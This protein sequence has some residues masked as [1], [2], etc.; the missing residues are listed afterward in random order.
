MK[1][2]RN[3]SIEGA[4][5][6]EEQLNKHLEK[7]AMQ[8]ELKNKSDLNTYPIP[9][10]LESYKKIKNVYNLLSENIKL[11]I[12]IHPA[13]EWILDNFYVIEE[14][15]R[16]IEKELNE[17]KYTEFIGIQ[18]GKYEGFARIYVLATEMVAYTDNKID[19]ENLKKYLQAYQTK[20][21]L[22]MEE[23]WNIGLFL[24]IA[25]IK[26]IAELCEEIYI[27]QIQK[28]KVKSII[29]RLVENKNKDELKYNKI[30]ENKLTKYKSMKYPFIEYMTYSLKKYGKKAHK[31]LEILEQE[32]EKTGI[33]VGEAIQKEHFNTAIQTISMANCITS[34]KKIQRINFL[35]IFENVNEVEE[36]LKKDP[37]KI[38]QKME[39]KTKEYYR[40][41]IKEI[42][43]KTKI[44]EVYIARKAIELCENEENNLKYKH[45][46]YYLID[47]GIDEL[48][49]K[50]GMA[51]KKIKNNTKVKLYISLIIIFT[52]IISILISEKYALILLIP[53][54]EIVIQTLQCILGK[55][56]K[57]K[58]IPKMD[59][60]D[61][62]NEEN[63]T[64]VVIPTIIKSK[65]KVKELF[66]K[67]EVTYLSNKSKNLYFAVL[68]DCSESNKE[69]EQFDKEVEE[70]GIEEVE[71]LNKKY[72]DNK[73]PKFHFIYRRRKY[74]PSEE[75]YL[76]WERKRGLLT[77]FNEYILKHE[78]NKFR[79][80]TIEKETLPKIK[81][82]ITLD[83]DT[84]LPLNTA[85]ELVG[86]MAHILNKPEI[87]KQKNIV[88]NGHALIQPR[89]GVNLEIS[90]KNIFTKI[91]AG[92]GGIDNYTNAISDIYQDNFE[93]GIFTG[94]G[95][96]N[97]EIFSKVLNNEIP[98]NTV[99][100]HDL[101]EGCYLRCGLATDIMLMDG[102]PQKYMSFMN[103]L[104]RWTRGDWQIRDW[105]NSKLNLL[106]KYKILDNL[107]RSLLE[108]FLL[109]IV[110]IEPISHLG[111]FI[112]IYPF[113]LEILNLLILRK[114]GEKKQKTFEPQIR[115]IKGAIYRAIITLGCLPYKAYI[116][117]VSIIKTIYRTRISHKHLLE[118]MTSEEAE[119]ASKTT[120]KQYYENMIVN[121]VASIIIMMIGIANNNVLLTIIGVLWIIM[122]AIMCEISK[123]YQ[124]NKE[125]LNKEEQE[126]VK[127]IARKTWGF[128]K[129]Y[130]TQ[131][132]NFLIPDNYQ[133]DRKNSIVL[134]TSSTN[135]GLSM[136]AVI[137]SYDLGFE[138]LEDTIEL[139]KNI[140]NTIYE[141]KK[142][143]G[144]LYNWYNIRTKETLKP[145]YI[146]TVDSGNLVGY[147]YTT[148]GFLKEIPET[149]ELQTK[150]KELI[151]NTDFK[152]LYSK[153]QRLF[154]IGY[155]VE[156]NKLTDS[157]YD[158]L[159]S[160]A[161]QASLI[162]IAKRD[163][164]SKQW[165]NLSR[166]L[167]VLKKHKGLISWSG[168]SFEYLM[169]NINIPKYEGSLLDESCKFL[170]M[171]QIEYSK[172]L[173]IPWGISEA[174]FNLKDLHSNY[175]Y[176]AFG[177]PWLGLKRGL[178]DEM[179][180]SSYGSIL[181]ITE[182]PKEVIQNIKT[183]EK[184]NM[185]GKYGLYE[186]IDFTPERMS[187]GKKSEVV[188][189]FMAHHQ[190]LIL[191][192][193]N[194]LLN[195][196]IFPKRFMKNPEIQA[197]NILLQERM[198][199]TFIIT[200]ENK[201]KAEKIK[202]KD[203]EDYSVREVK[204]NDDRIIRGN[205][206]GNEK[207]ITAINQ[208]GIG[209]SKF[210]NIYINR[211]KKTAD[212]NQ[213][214]FFYI[215]EHKSNKIW[216]VAGDEEKE[217]IV[218]FMPD[219]DV[220][221][222]SVGKIKTRLKIIVD[223]VEP[224][225]IRRLEIVNEGE[226]D[227]TLEITSY[228]EPVLSPKEPDYAHEAF[229]NLSLIYNYEKEEDRIIIKRKSREINRK[230]VY[231][232]A[233]LQT[234]AEKLQQTEYEIDKAKFIGR[235]NLGIPK[236]I[237]ENTKF[238]TKTGLVT[239]GII[240]IKNTIKVPK[241]SKV[242][243]DLLLSAEYIKK[244][245]IKNIEK[246]K[247]QEN[248]T[249]E[250]D[251]VKAK[252]E[253]EARYLEIKGKDINIYQ[254]ILSYILFDNPIKHKNMKEKTYLKSELWKYGISGDLPIIT[255]TVK[256]INDLYVVRQ[257]LKAY[258]YF[259]TKNINIDLVIIEED[260]I[261]SEIENTIS[262]N[263]M[264]Y[265]RNI[266][267]GIFVISRGELK[268]TDLEGIKFIS[269]IVLD[270]HLGNLENTIKDMEDEIIDNYK[271][272]EKNIIKVD[273]EDL[274]Q[275]IY[276]DE[277]D[278]K[279]YNGYGGFSLDGKEYIIGINKK[280]NLPTTWSHIIAN[281]KFGTVLTESY[282]GYTWYKNCRL[283]R[284]TSWHNCASVNIPSEAIYIYD[285]E[286]NKIWTPTAMPSP[287]NKSYST[288]YGFGYAKYLHSSD[289]IFQ[290]LEVFVPEKESLKINILTLKNNAPKKK[291]MKLY[292]YIKPV[293]GEDEIQSNGFI[294]LNNEK[295]SNMII[296]QN[297]YQTEDFENVIY[298][299][300]SEKI[301]SYT[302][303]KKAFFGK[304]GIQEPDMIY[305][306]G[307]DNDDEIQNSSCIVIEIEAEIESFSEKEIVFLLGAEE[308]IS[309]AKAIAEKYSNI[310][311]CKNAY[312]KIKNKWNNVL[313]KI[314]INTPCES[315]NILL[316]GWIMYQTIS[317][318]LL[319]KSG[320][321]QSG[322][323]DGF[324]DQLQDAISTKFIDS[325]I[326]YNQI[327]RN[328][329]HQFIEGDV[330]HWWH[331]ETQ[332]GIRTKF[333]DD[334]LWLPYAV[335]QYI[336][337]TGN[338]NI[339]NEKT[340]YLQGKE[341]SENELE[342]Y[343]KH[344]PSNVE[345]TIYEHCKKAIKRACKFG[346]QGL[347]KIG[348]GDW[349]DGF[350][351]IGPKGKGE[352]VWLGFFL[353]KI[354][355]EFSEI[356]KHMNE[357]EIAE[358]Y[359]DIADKLKSN[360]NQN[361]WDGQWYKRAFADNGDVYGSNVNEECKIDSIAQ[362][363]SIISKAGEKEKLLTAMENLE[364]YLIDKEN[365]II[366]LLTPPFE[367]SNLE[368][369]YIKAYL[370]GVRENGGQYT[371]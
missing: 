322:G 227:K 90:N 246:Y 193:I 240:A 89:V 323:A 10:L 124:N 238:S 352:S 232:I 108:I 245:A 167:T 281:E 24:Q 292:Y 280:N 115:G 44:S 73:F 348:S 43:K 249:R 39:Y 268:Q 210:E 235:N 265:L 234:N 79:I 343:D 74:N 359:N 42:S 175:Q 31:Y 177:V 21:K 141:L 188:K 288:I 128:F 55:I 88:I 161:R 9:Q 294:K 215:K 107:R 295:N 127:E 69:E 214:I 8:Q 330:E 304:G 194:N 186:S 339:L 163:V 299:S 139:L 328:S 206:I 14:T 201:E 353:Y 347:P 195:N 337:Y 276:I 274:T 321:Y 4:I 152:K 223:S 189:T 311:N 54:S 363:W 258:E 275:D 93:E 221:E 160:E 305:N 208:K 58:I 46:G 105:L 344:L 184:N 169:P 65:E 263:H 59:F 336:E 290:K 244:S 217:A 351:N 134:R 362:S 202:Y 157:Y 122:P 30:E 361:A 1:K 150:L 111:M 216:N 156:E 140:I 113:I 346:K 125:N 279:Y 15:V 25:I 179:V 110:F 355:K 174:A 309:D 300:S 120:L 143:N 228:F 178:A 104:S 239:E 153:E 182:K 94:K 135:I 272:I 170:I 41:A 61:G 131:E 222:T 262:N 277:K 136:L 289:E 2:Y 259:R 40:N 209:F 29:E 212:Y 256:Y 32:V 286:K 22:D 117:L 315:M 219:K 34:I 224:V 162:A 242:Y 60:Y 327:I 285:K 367:N 257:I 13:G 33:T 103:R 247:I 342:V 154:S 137:A 220:F 267:G 23:I 303:N 302:G 100:S 241:N 243:V 335:I 192:S 354:L 126:Y 226:K 35:E 164:S 360:L 358:E 313:G 57:P 78:K 231:L 371:H 340:P 95:I 301:K 333:S 6:D 312:T 325:Q 345:E 3:L 197:I 116:E 349:N 45:V 334:L 207:Y 66:R 365:G 121:I 75:K 36:I 123:V 314:Q 306:T 331:E 83:S 251:I 151:Q 138:T 278:L 326:L 199:E 284:I 181:A 341:L 185:F 236:M 129:E 369:G 252:T 357:D 255:V 148:L 205:V 317:S 213:G 364:K 204:Q 37:A 112:T 298:I 19:G 77:Q 26:N 266:R 264:S 132:N 5:I 225:E 273:E 316:N 50:I 16:Q 87:D 70:Q 260:Y 146:S 293:I 248:V 229:N 145:E 283:N 310:E 211:F 287:D 271:K 159:A 282:G 230:D 319:G 187:N 324:R 307:L 80:N 338:Y 99:L 28:Y 142:W 81:Y 98:E 101:L 329:K 308:K 168:T 20:K 172:K 149:D 48:Y 51:K 190:A 191:L 63:A 237:K 218:S 144:H 253:A 200:K 233:K 106:S 165:N 166:T 176:K 198:P 119:N 203:Y 85:F 368:P 102:Y 96:Y 291:K 72:P 147:M 196:Q 67:L 109:I 130:L 84:E 71:R 250:L 118:W 62:I 183:L 356:S 133:E 49:K 56:I 332:R 18:N 320:L 47:D 114:E 92:A 318:R 53:V 270:T 82:V 91:F 366:K 297:M 86:S 52:I 38:Y 17:K 269:E 350:N 97:V 68:G 76:G 296:A 27:N 155:N 11:E 254:T 12:N 180:V 261:K 64:F 370:P 171:N 158:L 173:G 7:I